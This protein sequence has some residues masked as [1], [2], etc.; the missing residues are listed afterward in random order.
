MHIRL[1]V[2][3]FMHVFVYLHACVCLYFYA[4]TCIH[5]CVCVCVCVRRL[6]V[7]V[8]VLGGYVIVL[9]IITRWWWW[10][11]QYPLGSS[12]WTWW[13]LG[14]PTTI[15]T[16]MTRHV[17]SS[18][19]PHVSLPK[20]QTREWLVSNWILT[21]CQLHRGTSEWYCKSSVP[22]WYSEVGQDVKGGW[23][24][25]GGGGRLLRICFAKYALLLTDTILFKW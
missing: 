6:R 5:V 20:L 2:F 7:C 23:L 9:I 18:H 24:G 10:C 14:G 15:Y 17:T 8:C 16:S 11:G 13:W 12:A 25:W 4:C 19:A 1:Y 21:S 3:V 22:G